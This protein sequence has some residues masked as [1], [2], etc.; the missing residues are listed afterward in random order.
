MFKLSTKK[1]RQL[2]NFNTV[3]AEH[4]TIHGNI[5]VQEGEGSIIVS[6][7]VTGD[8][9]V[10]GDVQISSVNCAV[11]SITARKIIVDGWLSDCDVL[12]ADEVVIN[13]TSKFP[14]HI[15]RIQYKSLTVEAGAVLKNTVLEY[16]GE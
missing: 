7:D 2:S 12:K 16:T 13:N 11:K 10:C 15:K 9:I 8:I 4:I 14:Q 5:S 6:G 3:I 1:S